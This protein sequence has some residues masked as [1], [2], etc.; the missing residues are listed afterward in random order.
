MLGSMGG[1][2]S[3]ATPRLGRELSVWVL[4]FTSICKQPEQLPEAHE[5]RT[6]RCAQRSRMASVS[7]D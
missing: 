1:L 4:P 5:H 7:S 2:Q 6:G 3:K